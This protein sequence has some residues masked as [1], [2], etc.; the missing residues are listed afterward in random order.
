MFSTRIKPTTG[1]LDGYITIY[2]IL[3]Y[4]FFSLLYLYTHKNKPTTIEKI[5]IIYDIMLISFF[6]IIYTHRNKSTSVSTKYCM[7]NKL[8]NSQ[9]FITPKAFIRSLQKQ[10]PNILQESQ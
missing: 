4:I 10:N 9:Y 8:K 1:H 2:M 5:M 7:K 6:S 3:C